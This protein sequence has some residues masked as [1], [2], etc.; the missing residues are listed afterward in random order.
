MSY[1]SLYH[2]ALDL[3][4]GTIIQDDPFPCC[5]GIGG[6]RFNCGDKY[7]EKSLPCKRY[8][9]QR[10]VKNWDK[11]CDIYSTHTSTF[12][13]DRYAMKSGIEASIGDQFIRQVI[14]KRYCTVGGGLNCKL[15]CE[16]FNATIPNSPEICDYDGNCEITCDQFTR[17]AILSDPLI[18]RILNKPNIFGDLILAIKK[19]AVN[20]GI[21]LSGTKFDPLIDNS[22]IVS[23][24]GVN[25]GI[26]DGSSD[27]SSEKYDYNDNSNYIKKISILV[28][29][30]FILIIFT[31]MIRSYICKKM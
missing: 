25:L 24:L 9:T 10:C 8:M 18:D 21:D 2:E 15:R 22:S 11:A 19:N 28:I 12:T 27:G 13:A 7:G 31:K 30:F 20:N 1:P 29:I 16:Q 5:L 14:E 6:E 17:D 4:P 26:A 3:G 23:N